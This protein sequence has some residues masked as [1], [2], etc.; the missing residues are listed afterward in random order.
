MYSYSQKRYQCLENPTKMIHII[1]AWYKILT[2]MLK[3]DILYMEVQ[4]MNI[5]LSKEEIRALKVSLHLTNYEMQH[6]YV[7]IFKT[8]LATL[9]DGNIEG[10]YSR[11]SDLLE[12][13]EHKQ[14]LTFIQKDK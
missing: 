5:N 3:Y 4:I 6:P 13:E 12:R 10:L 1:R 2:Y 11:L 8:D 14:N 9:Q 7:L